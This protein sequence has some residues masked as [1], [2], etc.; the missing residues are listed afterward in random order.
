M[1]GTGWKTIHAAGFAS[2][3]MTVVIPAHDRLVPVVPGL[4]PLGRRPLAQGKCMGCGADAQ[5]GFAVRDVF[6]DQAHGLSRKSP[7]PSTDEEQVRGCDGPCILENVSVGTFILGVAVAQGIVPECL[8]GEDGKALLGLVFPFRDE[9]DDGFASVLGS[10][11]AKKEKKEE[12][13]GLFHGLRMKPSEMRV[14]A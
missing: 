3:V 10:G 12:T 2:T 14:E 7:P 4:V 6:A 9:K 5:N 1:I 8:P 13:E 11:D